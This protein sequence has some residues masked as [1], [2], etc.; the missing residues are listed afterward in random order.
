MSDNSV[1]HLVKMANQIAAGVPATSEEAKV[2]SAAS[3]IEKFWTPLM[4]KQICQFLD[5]GGEGLTSVA[6]KAVTQL[7]KVALQ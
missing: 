6:A 7:D 2:E 5:Q 4:K 3:H 1:D